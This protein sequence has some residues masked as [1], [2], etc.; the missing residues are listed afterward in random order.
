MQWRRNLQ[1]FR[2]TESDLIFWPIY[3]PGDVHSQFS[4]DEMKSRY[5]VSGGSPVRSFVDDQL[6]LMAQTRSAGM[7]AMPP[8]LGDNGRRGEAH[9]G[10]IDPMYGPAVRCKRFS[11][12]WHSAVLHQCIR[13]LL[14]A[15]L[16]GPSWIS[17]RVRSRT[18]LNGPVGSP[19]SHAPGR[20]ILHLFVSSRRPRRVTV[21]LGLRHRLSFQCFWRSGGL[22]GGR[23]EFARSKLRPCAR[24]LKAMRASLL[25][26]AIART[27]RCSR[28]VWLNP[29]LSP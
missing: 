23:G 18:D 29:G 14:G 27:L 10:R 19:V 21:G 17:A 6:P 25:A 4:F 8:L 1:D 22:G 26:S 15:V 20:P 7:S 16:L 12:S 24:T 2:N 11:S 13:S 9:F 3:C 5:A 28:S